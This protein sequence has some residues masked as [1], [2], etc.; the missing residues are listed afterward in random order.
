MNTY[1]FNDNLV[2]AGQLMGAF[3]KN[4]V[5]NGFKLKNVIL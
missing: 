4:K 2:T 3:L 5:D 1:Q